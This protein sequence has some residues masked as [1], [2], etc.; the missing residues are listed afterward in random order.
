MKEKEMKLRGLVVLTITIILGTLFAHAQGDKGARTFTDQFN[1]SVT[2]SRFGTV[3]RFKNSNGKETVPA[4]VYRVCPCGEQGACIESATLPSE[5]TS[6]TLEVTSPKK[7]TTLRKGDTLVVTATFTQAGLTVKRTLTWE[8][9]SDSVI[10]D[11][12]ISSSKPLC[13][14]TLEDKSGLDIPVVALAGKMCPAPP[15]ALWTCPPSITKEAMKKAVVIRA[16][17]KAPK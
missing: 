17:L 1:Q 16:V 8:A 11:E 3:L 4:N 5:K 15:G 10:T 12:I 7:G 2:I 13:S 9:G 14:C 6:S